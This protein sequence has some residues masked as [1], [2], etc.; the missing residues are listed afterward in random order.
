MA[1]VPGIASLAVRRFGQAHPLDLDR[2]R[3]LPQPGEGPVAGVLGGGILRGDGSVQLAPDRIGEVMGLLRPPPEAGEGLAAQLQARLEF[4][5]HRLV[6]AEATEIFQLPGALGPN[7]NVGARGER[8]R[9]LDGEP[10][11]YGVGDGEHDQAGLGDAGGLQDGDARGVTVDR[12]EASLP[13]RFGTPGIGFY[14]YERLLQPIQQPGYE[15]AHPAVP[16]DDRVRAQPTL[17]QVEGTQGLPRESPPEAPVKNGC[18]PGRQ[19]G[20]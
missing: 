7:Q 14:N 9:P 15:G 18:E 3:G 13:G 6:D 17:W 4:R 19:G 20:E 12:R 5:L 1:T 16:G 10:G 8:L 11:G 2:P